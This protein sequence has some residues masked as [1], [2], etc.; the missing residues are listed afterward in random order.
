MGDHDGHRDRLRKRY[1]EQG[2]DG[3]EDHQL[4]ELL[5]F[6]AVPRKDTNV[7]AHKLISAFGSFDAVLEADMDDLTEVP[8]VGEGTAALL[9]LVLD[10]NRRYLR[11]KGSKGKYL[12]SSADIVEY[13]RGIF[14]AAQGEKMYMVC[15]DGDNRII[16]C[17]CISD[18]SPDTVSVDMRKILGTVVKSRATAVVLAHNHV[19]REPV[20]S[21]ADRASTLTVRRVLNE[22]GV[23]LL[24]H[25]IIAGEDYR[26]ID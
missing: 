8:G 4:L 9:K 24:D 19:G 15:L 26:F 21:V 23:T 22:V 3:F 25:V 14:Y 10:V 20:P 5:L 12:R 1:I 13:F 7:L 6:Y 17:S 16:S 11:C 2:A 18:G